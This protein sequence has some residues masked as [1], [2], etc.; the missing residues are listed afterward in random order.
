MWWFGVKTDRT[1]RIAFECCLVHWR[2]IHLRF[3]SVHQDGKKKK[4]KKG[5]KTKKETKAQKEKRLAREKEKRD[6][7]EQKD[8]E[9]A[10]KEVLSKAKKARMNLHVWFCT[11]S[12]PLNFI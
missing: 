1:F 8:K 12:I 9:K 7:E 3:N 2:L 10:E 4:K 11:T 5:K 6:K